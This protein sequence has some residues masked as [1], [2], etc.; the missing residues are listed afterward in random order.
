[1]RIAYGVHGFGRG[2]AMRALA[3][4]PELAE[5]HELLILAGGDAYNAL[6]PD[7]PVARIP[8][9]KYH[10]GKRGKLSNY[11]NAK[12]NAAMILDLLTHGPAY[13]MVEDMIRGFHPDVILTDSEAYTHHLGRGLR[14]PRITFDHFGLLVYCRPEMSRWDRLIRRG[15]AFVYRTLFG[16]PDR[17]VVSGF[18]HAPAAREGV[19][20]VGPV[21]REE[22]R[23]LEPTRGEH[24]VV[25]V[26]K[27][28]E[29]SPDL[30]RALLEVGCPARVYGT[31]RRGL[32]DNLH[33]KPIANLPFIEDLASC[34]AVI[35]TTGNQLSGE[36]IYFGKPMLG[37]PMACLEQRLNAVQLETRGIGMQAVR[38]RITADLLRTFLAREEEFL[39][40]VRREFRDGKREALDA[41]ERF[42]DELVGSPRQ[43]TPS[44]AS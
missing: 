18:F 32:Q 27:P 34:R 13:Q 31:P 8:T 17:A 15:N 44:P 1:L 41:I 29:F 9:L 26:S 10:Y 33:F 2:H 28:D 16:D 36:V 40:N 43:A 37:K 19:C 7:Y 20:V 25:Y 4:L 12:R 5:R 24:L 3:V 6:W 14:I 38:R 42:A 11:L 30:E 35:G 21:I 23:R 39:A 22:V